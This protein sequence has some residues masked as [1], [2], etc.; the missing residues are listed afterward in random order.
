MPDMP[1]RTL[2][3][4]VKKAID[5]LRSDSGRAWKMGEIARLCG[6]P[7]RTLEKHFTRFLGCAPLKFLHGERFEQARRK[8][9]R[10]PPGANVTRIAS[11][12]GFNHPGRFALTYRS[13]YGES[14]SDTL[15]WGHI[16]AATK[17][18]SFRSP[19]F[20]DRPTLA[21]IPFDRTGPATGD[22]A[23]IGNEIAAALCGTG[24]IK[25]LPPPAGRYHLHG[26]VRNDG[27]GRSRIRMT[28][29][30]R[31]ANR[32]IWAESA[33]VGAGLD[34]GFQDWL[35]SL[36]TSALRS[37]VRD[38]EIDRVAGKDPAQLTAW[39]LSMRAL[40]MVIAA[41]PATHAAALELLE[42]AMEL[43][44]RDPVPMA[45][46][47]WCRG[48]RAGHHFTHHQRTERDEALR[49]ASDASKLS[50]GDPL[51]DTM[52]SAAHM[53]AHDLTAAEAHARRALVT[54]GGSSW[55]WGR[56]GWVHAYRGE[57]RETIE[58]CQIAH[59]LAPADPLGFVWSIG[60]AAAN[61]ELGRY[62]HAVR[63]YQRALTD[64][65]K[66]IWINRFLAPALSLAGRKDDA[67]QSLSA[68]GRAFPDLTI[69][70]V[71]QGLPHTN[72]L[73]DRVAEG[74]GNLGMPGS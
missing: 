8:L 21:V 72:V 17:Q 9:L 2:P 43:T 60:I 5:L 10:A 51:A 25:V 22:I 52:L 44:P 45:L 69:A 35:S 47:A 67:K 28:L 19:A 63:G 18:S 54:D 26:S 37:I 74:L 59:A 16:P 1:G 13:R 53:L 71:R 11:E 7:R 32:Y 27:N 48:L 58:H 46:A 15:S 56:L 49:L 41:D 70:E 36:A 65:P 34:A 66:A 14:P 12:C 3:R 33:E 20:W 64:Q 6:V 39:E 40:P 42:R 29:L 31:P 68:L 73:L 62:D 61:F 4:D 50:A 24:W 30:D 55:A 38:A 23:D 57:A